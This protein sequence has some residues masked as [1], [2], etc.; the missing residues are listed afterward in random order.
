M[1][2][3]TTNRVTGNLSALVYLI[4]LRA[5]RFVHPT[6]RHRAIEMGEALIKEFANDG[7]VLH[8]DQEPDRFDVKRGEQDIVRKED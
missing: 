6:L 5:T 3:N 7:L 8:L 2:F 1:G 4:E